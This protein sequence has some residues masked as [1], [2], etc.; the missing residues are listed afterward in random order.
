MTFLYVVSCIRFLSRL[1]GPYPSPRVIVTDK[2]NSYTKPIK[3]MT[4]VE[5]RRHKGLNN[6]VE[7]AHQPTRR[8]EKSLIKFKSPGGL[9][10]TLTLMSKIRN[11]F[12]VPVARYRNSASIQKLKFNEAINI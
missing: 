4:K 1:L 6:T 2:L 12:A 3:N 9:Q 8:K 11:I 10:R 5:H 7:N